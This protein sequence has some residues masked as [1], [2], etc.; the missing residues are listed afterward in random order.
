M[1]VQSQNLWGE[2]K[3][4]Q[5]FG[6]KRKIQ[7]KRIFLFFILKNDVLYWYYKECKNCINFVSFSQEILGN[8]LWYKEWFQCKD[9]K[10]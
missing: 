3:D 6:N 9:L 10:K 2:T 1:L 4:V 7:E 5:L 8:I